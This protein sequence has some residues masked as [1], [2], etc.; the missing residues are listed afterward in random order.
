MTDHTK[1]MNDALALMREGKV[2]DADKLLDSAVKEH[3]A[4]TAPPPPPPPRPW[5]QVLMAVLTAM[6]EHIGSHPVVVT[7]LE[8][9]EQALFKVL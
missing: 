2:D 5:Q 4:E 7:A 8:E 9:L 3:G 1:V 6:S